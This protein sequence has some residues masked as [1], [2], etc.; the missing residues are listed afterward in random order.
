MTKEEAYNSVFLATLTGLCANP[1]I[2]AE[3][4]SNGSHGSTTQRDGRIGRHK[5]KARRRVYQVEE[6]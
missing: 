2:F 3:S 1:A 5:R 6:E 4:E